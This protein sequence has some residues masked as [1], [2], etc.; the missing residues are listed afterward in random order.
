[1]LS[2]RARA[3]LV[4]AAS[5]VAF[6]TGMVLVYAQA[7][8]PAPARAAAPAAAEVARVGDQV[9]TLTDVDAAWQQRDPAS[10][11]Q[12]V[13]Q[14]YDGRREVL[15]Q[16]VADAVIAQAAKAK[17]VAQDAF[18]T[19]ELA[20]RRK[21]VADADVDA[22]YT[23]NRDR[24]QGQ[25]IDAMRGPIRA[26]LEEQATVG[27]RLALVKDLEAARP[28]AVSV[29]LEPP[30]VTVSVGPTD[31]VRGSKT[32][33]IEIVE[34]SDF[35]CPFCGRVTP[36]LKQVMDAYGDRVHLV[37]KDFPLPN[38]PDAPKA[39]EA[40]HCAGEQHQYWEMHDALFANQQALKVE[41]LKQY[42]V[43][44]GL[45]ATTFNECL[46]SGRHGAAIRAATAEGQR[47]G[48]TSTPS[49][50]INGRMIVGAQPFEAFKAVIDE[51]LARK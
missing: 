17:G 30:R 44:L 51:E 6:A 25:A 16:L 45:D 33:P 3:G 21:A 46:D 23:Q 41:S 48:I 12:V 10:R 50:F 7:S 47:I 2:S 34:F 26:F 37:F 13:Q 31:P 49:L 18:L 40:A 28:G 1:M 8:K 4:V 35:Q 20:H 32:G 29:T 39:A 9:I 27:A 15:E 43:K 38:H 36:V 5:A 11:N 22:F 14:L 42:A 24:M 19:E